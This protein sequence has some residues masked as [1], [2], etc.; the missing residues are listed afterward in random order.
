MEQERENEMMDPFEG[1]S[2]RR[3]EIVV[4]VAVGL[5]SKEIALRL[6]PP[7]G[8]GT[9][10]NHLKVIFAHTGVSSRAALASLWERFHGENTPTG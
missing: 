3:M 5:A 10:K 2:A 4:L 7:I 9:V 8:E 6:V 1:L